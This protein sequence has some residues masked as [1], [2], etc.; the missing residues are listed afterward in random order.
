MWLE[1]MGEARRQIGHKQHKKRKKGIACNRP[2]RRFLLRSLRF[3]EASDLVRRFAAS[4]PFLFA[5]QLDDAGEPTASVAMPSQIP[6]RASNR[7]FQLTKKLHGVENAELR[8]SG[9]KILAFLAGSVR[10]HEQMPVTADDQLSIG[11]ESQV[12]IMRIIRVMRV[13]VDRRHVGQD[14]GIR[15]DGACEFVGLLGGDSVLGRGLEMN[16][17]DFGQNVR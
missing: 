6:L 9:L 14:V 8:K 4:V 11:L 5:D 2:R 13:T 17:T 3:L 10:Q 15:G 16:L 7:R 12:H 1:R